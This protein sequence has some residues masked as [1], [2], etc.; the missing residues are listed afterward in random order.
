MNDMKRRIKLEIENLKLF[1]EDRKAIYRLGVFAA[2]L[3]VLLICGIW[4]NRSNAEDETLSISKMNFAKAEVSEVLKENLIK[5]NENAEGRYVG[6]QELEIRIT[7]GDHKNEIMTLTNYLSALYNVHVQK[8]DKIIVRIMENDQ[9]SYYASMYN[10][11]RGFVMGIFILVFFSLLILL[12]GKKG[13]GA[14]AGLLFTLSCIWFILIPAVIQ[15]MNAIGMTIVIIAVTTTGSLIMLNGFSK[16]TYCAILGCIGGVII[17][18][19][20][21]VIVSYLTP[22]NGFNMS[23]AENLLLYGADKGL[24]ISGLL[25]CSVLISA[26]GAV[27]DVSL[28]IA[29]SI[30]ELHIQNQELPKKELFISGMRIGRDAMGTMANTL[31]LAFAGSALNMLILIQTYEIPFI[32]LINTDYICLEIIQSIASS[33]GILLTVPLVAMISVNLMT[34]Q[35]QEFNMTVKK[36]GGKK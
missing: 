16:K 6:N 18:G 25:V 31:I 19:L 29:S 3:F 13:I 20:C 21:A 1:L 33:M 30:W 22:M 12:G 5:D 17:A 2:M 26:L 4:V 15:G 34:H 14:L 36:Q 9:G 8:G 28:G 7:S 10:Y 24:K 27:M 32:Q 23:E 11:N 35:T